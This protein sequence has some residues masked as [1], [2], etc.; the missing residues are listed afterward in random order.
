M[1]FTERNTPIN[2]HTVGLLKERVE[3]EGDTMGQFGVEERNGMGFRKLASEAQSLREMEE[4][5]PKM[6]SKGCENENEKER[7]W[8]NSSCGVGSLN[9][10]EPKMG[11][12]PAN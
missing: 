6:L 9:I 5:V 8:D 3:E 10:G 12:T 1:L 7:K 11:Q 4:C 2:A